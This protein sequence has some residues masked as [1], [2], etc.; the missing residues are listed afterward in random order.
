MLRA[1]WGDNYTGD[2]SVLRVN[3]SRL[4]QKI[5]EDKHSPACHGG[6]RRLYDA[7]RLTSVALANREGFVRPSISY[8][9]TDYS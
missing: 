6:R 3:I 1:V 7:L 4:R 9:V 2:F 8:S 5:E